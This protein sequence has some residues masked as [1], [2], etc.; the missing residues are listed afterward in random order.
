MKTGGVC[1]IQVLLALAEKATKVNNYVLP[2]LSLHADGLQ[3]KDLRVVNI[4]ESVLV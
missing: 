4:L 1:F 3:I 2:L